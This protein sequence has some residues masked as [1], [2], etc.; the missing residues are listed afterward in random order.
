MVVEG[1]LMSTAILG[2]WLRFGR[3]RLPPKFLLTIPVYILW[4]I[5]LYIKFLVRRQTKWVRTDRDPVDSE[6]K[7]S[8]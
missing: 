7:S 5:P 4:K 8:S 3:D 6:K 1:V 2:A